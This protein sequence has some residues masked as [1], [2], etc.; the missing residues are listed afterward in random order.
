MVVT[1]AVGGIGVEVC[2]GLR[3][4]GLEPFIAD[5]D[6]VGAEALADELACGWFALDVTSAQSW[7][8]MRQELIESHAVV[9]GLVANAGLAGEI[10]AGLAGVCAGILAGSVSPYLGAATG[11]NGLVAMEVNNHLQWA[12]T[13]PAALFE[14][15]LLAFVTQLGE[16]SA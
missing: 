2:R 1:G 9:T 13:D 7:A 4:A 3:A 11:L 10:A 5:V 6:A 16:T 8:A 14:L 15:E 12:V